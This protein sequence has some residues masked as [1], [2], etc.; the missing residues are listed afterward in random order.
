MTTVAFQLAALEQLEAPAVVFEQT[1]GWAR[2]VGIVSDRP[3]YAATNFARRHGMNYGF[4]S[5]PR[6]LVE[7][8]PDIRGQPE[9][10]ADRYLLIGTDQ[11]DV[12]QARASGWEFLSIEEAA[13][14]AGWTLGEPPSPVE[15]D[16]ARDGW[17]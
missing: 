7:S 9:H 16:E 5:G 13:D 3:T 12:E 17:P 4:H 10:E 15:T 8:L 14:A 1:R 11:V 2:S 6:S